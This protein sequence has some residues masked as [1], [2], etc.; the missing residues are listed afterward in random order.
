MADLVPDKA[1]RDANLDALVEAANEFFEQEKTRLDSE[2]KF[3]RSVLKKRGADQVAALNLR[4]S[5]L[6]MQ[7][8]IANYL[9]V[10]G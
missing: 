7:D 8:E 4:E 10:G 6:S 5:V 1:T 9:F 2:S 3:L